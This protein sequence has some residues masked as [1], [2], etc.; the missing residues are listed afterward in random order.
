LTAL[1]EGYAE[2]VAQMAHVGVRVELVGGETA[3]VGDLVSTVIADS[4]VAVRLPRTNVVD[5]SKIRVGHVIVGLSSTGRASYEPRENSG[6]G[7]N[8][9][10]MARHVLLCREYGDRYPETVS[11]TV[12]PDRAYRGRYRLTDKLPGSSMTV[13]EALLSPTR[14]YAPIVRDVLAVHKK[15]V[16]GIIHCSGGGQVKA[17]G[18]GKQL[19]I[20]KDDLFEPPPIFQLLLSDGMVDLAEAFQ[21]FN[22]G[23]RLEI[24]CDE[25]VADS[26]IT[27]ARNYAVDAKVVG[28]V[29]SSSEGNRLS[30]RFGGR[31][32][33]Y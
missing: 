3:D 1:V 13:G 31:T 22:M 10:S 25:A 16:S 12:D 28:H 19:H 8:G 27:I 29:E 14:T 21:V 30:I 20:I 24:Y 26:I 32:F 15:R 23:H 18:F 9:F 17:R 2:F 33:E 7:S 5:C 6:I 11:T 4:T